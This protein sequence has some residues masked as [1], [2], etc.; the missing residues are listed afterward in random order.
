MQEN[1]FWELIESSKAE[2]TPGMSDQP[3]ILQ[4]KLEAMTAEEIVGF[5]RIFQR[6]FTDAYTWDLW[7]AGY[8]I[9]G[10]CSDDGFMDFRG[11]LIGLGRQ[12]YQDAVK[13]PQTLVSQPR[14]GV[15]FSNEDMLYVARKA[16]KVVTSGA[17]MPSSDIAC[18]D[19]PVGEPWE[20]ETVAAKYPRLVE[21][22]GFEG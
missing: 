1:I 10:G 16:Y 8:L 21:H 6:L 2:S 13:D 22:F 5:D 4:A 11:G 7:A 12:V 9:E 15:D 3:A 20:Q 19:D 18:P 14:R 17:E